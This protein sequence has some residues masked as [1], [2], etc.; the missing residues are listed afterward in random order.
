MDAKKERFYLRAC[1]KC[2]FRGLHRGRPA[3]AQV[4]P[5]CQ[6]N[7]ACNDCV[8][9][10]SAKTIM[11]STFKGSELMILLK[12]IIATIMIVVM[13]MVMIMVMMVIVLRTC[14]QFCQAVSL[15]PRCNE[16]GEVVCKK[17]GDHRLPHHQCR[18]HASQKLILST[19]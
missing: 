5:Q 11:F 6:R 19:R 9:V 15:S 8:K 2:A 3:H 12:L 13:I 4:S 1:N 10:F 17:S 18:H 14:C 16:C 7:L